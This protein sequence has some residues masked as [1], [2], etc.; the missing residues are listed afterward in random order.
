M[1]NEFYGFSEKPFEVT[2]DPKFLYLTSSHREA[3]DSMIDGVKNR[4]GLFYLTGE[5][6]T[7]KTTLVY[8]L[9]S[10]LNS[11][12]RRIKTVYIFHSTITFKELLKNILLELNLRADGERT[13]LRRRLAQYL[14]QMGTDESIATI[15]DEAQKLSKDVIGELQI[16]LDLEPKKIQILLVGQ[17]ELESKLG[18]QNLRPL[19]D[20]IGTKHHIEALTQEEAKEYIDHRLRLVGSSISE[21]F[22]PEALSMICLH[23]KG[24][25]RVINNLC[26]NALMIGYSLSERHIDANIVRQVLENMEG[27]VP[28]ETLL[29]SAAR[30]G[31]AFMEPR[32]S[33]LKRNF[34]IKKV[35]LVILLLL[36]LGG[37]GLLSKAYFRRRPPMTLNSGYSKSLPF[38][39]RSSPGSPSPQETEKPSAGGELS[40]QVMEQGSFSPGNLHPDTLPSSASLTGDSQELIQVVVVKERET[41]SSLARRYYRLVDPTLLDLILE[42]NPGID[43]VNLIKV[44]QKIKIPR[45]SDELRIMESSLHTYR[46]YVGTFGTL[47]DA[48]RFKSIFTDREVEVIPRRISPQETW[49]RVMVGNFKNK[50]Q[51]LQAIRL[52]KGKKLL[53]PLGSR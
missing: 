51:A 25:P 44:D 6:G 8:S 17:P 48:T 21:V 13:T 24:I 20:R 27:P 22:T 26:D 43:N 49:Y 36:C 39:A 47:G 40:R 53:P 50:E 37:I 28:E 52:F 1:Y 23:A 19:W 34:S 18:S 46:I 35:S 41:L 33:I 42:F 4:T 7:G 31:R 16:L 29:A 14:A 11:L 5:A 2:P 12:D 3:L 32:S 15:I 10:R 38:D 45:I 9:L 30:V